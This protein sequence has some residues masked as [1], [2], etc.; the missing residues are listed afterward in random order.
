MAEEFGE[1]VVFQL[2][3]WNG[4]GE[5]ILQNPRWADADEERCVVGDVPAKSDYAGWYMGR[6]ITIPVRAILNW[7]VVDSLEDYETA[8]KKAERRFASA[9]VNR[10][11]TFDRMVQVF[12]LAGSVIIALHFFQEEPPTWGLSLAW[13]CLFAGLIL[14]GRSPSN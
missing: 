4:G 10:G 2:K 11:F 3:G 1:F 7:I 12:G 13:V 6:T 8:L 14:P 9:Q 5:L